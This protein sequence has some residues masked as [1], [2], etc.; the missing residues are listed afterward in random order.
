MSQW[1]QTIAAN[2]LG[3]FG[4]NEV[5][6]NAALKTGIRA[7]IDFYAISRFSRKYAW[8][9]RSTALIGNLLVYGS[10]ACTQIKASRHEHY[11]QSHVSSVRFS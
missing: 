11:N 1:V 9:Q 8:L 3:P 10:S 4:T 7:V 2:L 6:R 5:G